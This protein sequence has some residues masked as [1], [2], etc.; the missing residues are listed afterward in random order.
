MYQIRLL[1]FSIVELT[2]PNISAAGNSNDYANGA[3]TKVKRRYCNFLS[4]RYFVYVH[5]LPIPT[6]F[7]TAVS[8][9]SKKILLA[10]TVLGSKQVVEMKTTLEIS[11]WEE[12]MMK[13]Y[14]C[15]STIPRRWRSWCAW[16]YSQFPPFRPF[17]LAHDAW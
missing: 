8:S 10:K 13:I 12:P 6:D 4:V 7:A 9:G 5:H 14:H 16:T 15:M 11:K 17:E 3:S 1:N 2:L